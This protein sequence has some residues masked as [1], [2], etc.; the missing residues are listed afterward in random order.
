MLGE[1]GHYL[2]SQHLRDVGFLISFV[3][4]ELLVKMFFCRMGIL[5]M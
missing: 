5:K 3:L 1:P 2:E 4:L